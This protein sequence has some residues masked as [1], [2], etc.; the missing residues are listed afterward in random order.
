M[1]HRSFLTQLATTHVPD[2]LR[3]SIQAPAAVNF[4]KLPSSLPAPPSHHPP[5]AIQRADNLTLY[6]DTSDNIRQEQHH[7]TSI[8]LHA[9]MGHLLHATAA[10]LL[11]LFTV[12]TLNLSFASAS[13]IPIVSMP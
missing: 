13:A 5:F 4:C 6:Q 1:A 10:M 3:S 2:R 7:A 11:L 8:T 12:L 9:T